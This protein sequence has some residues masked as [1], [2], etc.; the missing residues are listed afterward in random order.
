MIKNYLWYFTYPLN[1]RFPQKR[2][3]FL[4]EIQ[5]TKAQLKDCHRFHFDKTVYTSMVKDCIGPSSKERKRCILFNA[6]LVYC[7]TKKKS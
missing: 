1:V 2:Q 5:P 6:I 4:F 7:V 3:I